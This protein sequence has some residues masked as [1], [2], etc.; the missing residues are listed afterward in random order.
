MASR[1]IFLHRILSD[2]ERVAASAFYAKLGLDAP[3]QL[4]VDKTQ[5]VDEVKQA[6]LASKICSYAQGMNIIKAKSD[7]QGWDINLGEMARIWKGGCIIR[8]GFLGLIK[9]AYGRDAQLPNLLVDPYFGTQLSQ[10]VEAWRKIVQLSV[11]SG[12]AVPGMTASLAY[13]D[14][15]RRE[16]LPA[17]LVQSQRDFF[18]SHTYQRVDVEGS[19]HTVWD[20]KFGSED[21]ITTSGYSA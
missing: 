10:R 9:E 5:L 15:Y 1:S 13:F 12:L 6:L 20:P 21:S 17:N 16:R 18:G 14:T 4:S 19:Y 8:A 11:A 2:T 3:E 7:Q